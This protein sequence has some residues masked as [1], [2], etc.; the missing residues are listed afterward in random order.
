VALAARGQSSAMQIA[1]SSGASFGRITV[2][3]EHLYLKSLFNA[4]PTAVMSA[5]AMPKEAAERFMNLW[6]SRREETI[7]GGRKLLVHV[8]H[9]GVTGVCWEAGLAY[10][11]AAK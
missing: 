4:I 1:W 11:A 8:V 10:C 7:E 6:L 3:G 9:G 5:V 2:G